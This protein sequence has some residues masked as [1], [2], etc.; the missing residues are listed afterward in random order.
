MFVLFSSWHRG[1]KLALCASLMFPFSAATA[2]PEL[3]RIPENASS[4]C[5]QRAHPRFF[6]NQ[7]GDY[8]LQ[9]GA[10]GVKIIGRKSWGAKAPIP[11]GR[12]WKAYPQDKAVCSWYQRITVH[13]THGDYTPQS[14]QA[15]HQN[16]ADPKADSAYHFFIDKQGQIFE[17]RPLGR[18]GSHSERD[19]GANLGIAL[20]GNFEKQPPQPAQWQ[21]LQSLLKALDCPCYEQPIWTHRQRKKLNFPEQSHKW[22]S[23]PGDALASE[24]A[25][26]AQQS[27]RAPLTDIR[28]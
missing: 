24:V 1:L 5:R 18:M 7:G 25:Q 2:L 16:I 12:S 14:L 27:R 3:E 26:F 10:S 21:A 13:H 19:N 17:A 28:P 20:N 9:W 22:T 8:W 11:E 6:E 15:F 4:A 23:C